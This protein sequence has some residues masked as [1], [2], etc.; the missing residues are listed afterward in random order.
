MGVDMGTPLP[1]AEVGHKVYG[2]INATAT[3]KGAVAEMSACT[4]RGW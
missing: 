2:I 4:H 3:A 1:H